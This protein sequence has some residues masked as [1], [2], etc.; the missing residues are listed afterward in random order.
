MTKHVCHRQAA[1]SNVQEKQIIC[2]SKRTV[3]SAHPRERPAE[4]G[5]S[6]DHPTPCQAEEPA[7]G[8]VKPQCC[9]RR[10]CGNV[11]DSLR[12][13]VRQAW[14]SVPALPLKMCTAK[15]PSALSIFLSVKSQAV[16]RLNQLMYTKHLA[17]YLARESPKS[18]ML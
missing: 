13:G 2:F 18:E 10:P 17:L 5:G 7:L 15:V 12:S 11:G 16:M 8:H 1:M 4:N 3:S 9:V 14:V 6:C